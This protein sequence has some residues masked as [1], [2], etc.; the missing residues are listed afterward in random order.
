MSEK[1][2]KMHDREWNRVI[3]AAIKAKEGKVSNDAAYHWRNGKIF[4]M[5]D[6]SREFHWKGKLVAKQWPPETLN[7]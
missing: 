2:L 3:R 5:E 1:I 6:G 7:A 4:I